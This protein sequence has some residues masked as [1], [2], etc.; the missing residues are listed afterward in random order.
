M[1]RCSHLI[2]VFLKDRLQLLILSSKN[3]S[4]RELEWS[5]EHLSWVSQLFLEA[6]R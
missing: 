6:D 4:A 1:T 5:L 2:Q 3:Y